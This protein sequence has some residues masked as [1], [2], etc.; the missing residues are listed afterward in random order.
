MLKERQCRECEHC[1]IKSGNGLL[2]DRVVSLGVASA[3]FAFFR[4]VS[5]NGKTYELE[6]EKL[7][8]KDFVTCRQNNWE[9]LITNPNEIFKGGAFKVFAEDCNDYCPA[10]VLTCA[11]GDCVNDAVLWSE[12]H[13]CFLCKECAETKWLEPSVLDYTPPSEVAVQVAPELQSIVE[14]NDVE[15]NFDSLGWVEDEVL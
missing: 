12:D 13:K 15:P 3:L 1:S 8:D 4:S 5:A 7:R 14:S 11:N 10:G 2:K 9:G 6:P